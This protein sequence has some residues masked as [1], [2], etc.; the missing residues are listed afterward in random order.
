MVKVNIKKFSRAKTN[1]ES[2][3]VVNEPEMKLE[4]KISK[5]RT[6]NIIKESE[7]VDNNNQS[8]S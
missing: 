1:D 4:T 6:K 3:P 5:G 2:S 8:R 7:P